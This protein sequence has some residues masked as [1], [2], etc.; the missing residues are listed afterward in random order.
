MGHSGLTLEPYRLQERRSLGREVQAT[1]YQC[2]N[3]CNMRKPKD[4]KYGLQNST[5]QTNGNP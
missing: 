1:G 5:V 2:N 4:I 3:L